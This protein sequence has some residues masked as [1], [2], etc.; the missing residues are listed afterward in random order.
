MP[1][2]HYSIIIAPSDG[3]KS[4]H[5][6]VSLRAVVAVGAALFAIGS[7]VAFLAAT[8]GGLA[9]KV[10]DWED[11]RERC[12]VLEDEAG[13]V[14]DLQGEID[15]LRDLDAQVRR[16]VGLPEPDPGT[17]GGP[18]DGEWGAPGHADAEAVVLTDPVMPDDSMRAVLEAELRAR[19]HTLPWPVDGFVSSR[20][21]EKR[22][23]GGV[24]GG[25]DI[26]APRN[27]VI[28]APLAGTVTD[29][30]WHPVYGHMAVVD[31]GHGLV[32]LYGHNARLVV[33]KGDRVKSGDA[34]SFLGSTGVSSAPHLHFEFRMNGYAIDPTYLL[35]PR[36]NS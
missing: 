3:S 32:S 17:S 25:I 26:A 19:R 11:L 14:G 16:L 10:R 30:G 23:T 18:T 35:E 7:G 31:H 24:H 1:G 6:N 34:V 8:Y 5:L 36:E 15:R 29:A 33:R 9:W 27:T 21:G 20:F 2:R 28:E 13:R 4:Y 22:A 12:A